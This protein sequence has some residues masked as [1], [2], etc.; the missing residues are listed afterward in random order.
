MRIDVREEIR[1]AVPFATAEQEA[2]VALGRTWAVLDHAMA[3][4]L[5]P[6]GVTPTQYNV[7]RILRGAGEAGLSRGEVMERMITRV[8]DATRLLGRLESARLIERR[9][10]GVDRRVVRAAITPAGLDLLAK[11]EEPVLAA[12]GRQFA[13]LSKEEVRALVGLLDRIRAGLRAQGV[14]EADP[15]SVGPPRAARAAR[16]RERAENSRGR[17]R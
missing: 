10:E 6:W 7:L 16:G 9:R 15:G 4:A 12:H 2:H 8:P 3:G 11:L 14:P 5:K 1:Q 17:T 13:G